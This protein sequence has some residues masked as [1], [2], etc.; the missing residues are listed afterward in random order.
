[1]L[2]VSV[3]KESNKR[4]VGWFEVFSQRELHPTVNITLALYAVA[5]YC[6]IQYDAGIS[7]HEPTYL[8]LIHI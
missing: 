6:T 5:V 1:M 2:A 8:S 7:S 3:P 4:P